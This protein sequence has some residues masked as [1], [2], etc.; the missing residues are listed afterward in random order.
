METGRKAIKALAKEASLL[1][2]EELLQVLASQEDLTIGIPKE[3]SLQEK[4]VALVPE[5]V[6]LLVAHGHEVLVEAGAGENSNFTDIDYS[7]SGA[8]IIHDRKQVFEAG[9]ILKVE[10]PSL[11]EV[12][13]ME[14]GATLISALQLSVQNKD[15]LAKLSQK[16]I[17]AIAWD[18][19]R[20]NN[21][22]YPLV[23]AMGEI[24][25]NVSILI[26]GNL[27]SGEKS[28]SAMLGGISGVRPSEI[29]ILGAG[30]VGEFAAR[31][32]M[33][34][35]A[36]VK[37][38]DNRPHRLV[39]IQ[40]SLGHRVWTS[41]LQPSVLN[42]ALNTADVAIGAFRGDGSRSPMIVSEPMVSSMK[43]GSVII[44][45]CIDRGGC[46]ETSRMTSHESPTYIEHGVIHYC[47]P[48]I[49]SSVSGTAS[50]ALSN[51]L[52]PFILGIVS[53]GG[54]ELAIRGANIVKSGVYMYKGVITN[55]D[56]AEERD[57][58]FKDL[59]LFLATF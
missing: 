20:N 18:L 54:L 52:A 14:R 33:G 36:Q 56:V 31:A 27:L 15:L 25:G 59:D 7:E 10:P 47:V 46:F 34:L 4:R 26:A 37:I 24:A 1:P 3:I 55:K 2:Q 21:G 8:R 35:G 39:R 44:D 41:T 42:E 5:A 43:E 57:L 19:I 48:N 45:V 30:T 29:V 50:Q 28:K 49:A 17:T 53:D 23:R 32:A 13:L 9:I 11:D 40:Q 12:A 38:F 16:R 6:A 58:P 22:L 51:I